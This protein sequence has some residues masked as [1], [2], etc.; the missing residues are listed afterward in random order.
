MIIEKEYQAEIW[1]DSLENL[2][3]V[4]CYVKTFEEIE[5]EFSF[6]SCSDVDYYGSI[7]I[8]WDIVKIQQP[9]LEDGSLQI[10]DYQLSEEEIKH[11]EEE[12]I[13]EISEEIAYEEE[14][15]Y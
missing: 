7:E 2:L 10:V 3:F 15:Y 4:D 6:N 12:L 1:C 5:G 14:R 13:D 9:S 11:V 8:D